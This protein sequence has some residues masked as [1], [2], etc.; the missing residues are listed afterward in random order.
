MKPD[1]K[2]MK[3]GVKQWVLVALSFGVS[4]GIFFSIQDGNW[5]KGM[6]L[7][8]TLGV[9]PRGESLGYATVI[10]SGYLDF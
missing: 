2:K 4:M 9:F 1:S 8:A 10:P 7:G 6:V 5:K 3:S